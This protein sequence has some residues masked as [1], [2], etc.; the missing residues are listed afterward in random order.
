M[1]YLLG[2]RGNAHRIGLSDFRALG[3][4]IKPVSKLL[5]GVQRYKLALLK[6]L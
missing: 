2:S 4:L 6:A 3:G 5:D 1:R